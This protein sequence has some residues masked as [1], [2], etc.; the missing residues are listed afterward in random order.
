MS[1]NNPGESETCATSSLVH[2]LVTV[3]LVIYLFHRIKLESALPLHYIP[4]CRNRFNSSFFL[5]GAMP[6]PT[7][8]QNPTITLLNITSGQKNICSS[9][10][11]TVCQGQ[12][13]SE[14][15]FY[16]SRKNSCFFRP[17]GE[18]TVFPREINVLLRIFLTQA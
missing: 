16:F 7:E 1:N 6:V 18:K 4:F 2:I 14:A 17:K 15:N 5:T 13:N 12:K 11:E 10:L 3:Y 8:S 9:W